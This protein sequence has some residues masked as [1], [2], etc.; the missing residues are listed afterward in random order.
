MAQLQEYHLAF[1]GIFVM[2]VTLIVQWGVATFSKAAQPAAVPGKMDE[3]LSHSSFVFRANRTFMN[4]VENLTVMLPTG[5]LA[6][7]IGANVFWTGV[8]IWVYAVA[9]I[10]HM[11]LYYKIA[12]EKN[13]SPRSYFFI[14]GVIANIALLV[15][16]GVALI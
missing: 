14:I 2:L 13:P 16:V 12:T 9:R 7:L 10:I 6:I 15:L 11:A 5:F 1:V 8:L 3:S 4:S